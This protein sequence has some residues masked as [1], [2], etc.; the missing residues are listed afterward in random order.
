[1]PSVRHATSQRSPVAAAESASDDDGLADVESQAFAQHLGRRFLARPAAEH[2]QVARSAGARQRRL[3]VA[4][5]ATRARTHPSG[6]R[7]SR[8]RCPPWSGRGATAATATPSRWD[9]LSDNP[10]AVA[11]DEGLRCAVV[12]RPDLDA[13]TRNIEHG[14]D[15]A[16]SPSTARAAS[17]P[18]AWPRPARRARRA[19]R[20]VSHSSSAG[21]SL[22]ARPDATRTLIAERR[23]GRAPA[24]RRGRWRR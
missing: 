8:D 24:R 18:A 12:G 11:V 13:V 23:C 1:M 20:S 3:F 21:T 22:G 4:R 19:R 15:A 17:R 7:A 16:T 14:S 10:A 9:R 6:S 5:T 2:L